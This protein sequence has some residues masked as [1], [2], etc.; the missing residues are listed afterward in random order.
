MRDSIIYLDN[1]NEENTVFKFKKVN[2]ER[3]AV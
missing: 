1:N 3:P 2:E